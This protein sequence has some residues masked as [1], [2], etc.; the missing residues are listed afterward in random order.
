MIDL[1]NEKNE[2]IRK[3]ENNNKKNLNNNSFVFLI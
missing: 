2:K 3:F 1:N